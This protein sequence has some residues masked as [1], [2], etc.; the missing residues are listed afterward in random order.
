MVAG[1]D[2]VVVGGGVVGL[3]VGVGRGVVELA[4]LGVLAGGLGVEGSS[5]LTVESLEHLRGKAGMTEGS[6]GW[7]AR[8]CK[9]IAFS[10]EA[11]VVR[12][13]RRLPRAG[14]D[15]AREIDSLA[16]AVPPSPGPV[17]CHQ[18]P[19]ALPRGT[20]PRAPRPDLYC[21]LL[22]G[23]TLQAG[24]SHGT[25]GWPPKSPMPNTSAH[26]STKTNFFFRGRSPLPLART[27][28]QQPLAVGSVCVI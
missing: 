16:P 21:M 23:A 12:Q 27:G 19:N 7:L 5:G 3:V 18:R 28:T 24:A 20:R 11:I 25:R 1:A 14:H 10:L 13:R 17:F 15:R 2:P 6:D 26:R 8:H 4:G 22:A 9:I